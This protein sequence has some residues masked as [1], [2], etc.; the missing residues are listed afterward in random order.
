MK[1][2]FWWVPWICE[3]TQTL[4]CK[5]LHYCTKGGKRSNLGHHYSHPLSFTIWLAIWQLPYFTSRADR[6]Y[7]TQSRSRS[8]PTTEPGT[9]LILTDSLLP[10]ALLPTWALQKALHR[11]LKREFL[12]SK[13][14]KWEACWFFSIFCWGRKGTAAS[15]ISVTHVKALN[16]SLIKK[17]PLC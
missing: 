14:H 13:C 3:P 16:A 8:K 9:D 2:L 1:T 15:Y 17:L 11:H 5:S 10:R 4:A 7:G 12:S 6:C